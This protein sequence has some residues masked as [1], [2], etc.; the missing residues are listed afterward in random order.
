MF[1]SRARPTWINLEPLLYSAIH[2]LVSKSLHRSKED[3]A[4]L[5]HFVYA[6]SA[7]NAFTARS[8]LTTLQRRNHVSIPAAAFRIFLVS[9]TM[10]K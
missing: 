10:L 6:A 8:I 5:S 2:A 4:P 9:L 7:G 3:S 1:S